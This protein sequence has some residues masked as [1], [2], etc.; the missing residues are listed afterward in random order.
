VN[1]AHGPVSRADYVTLRR[2]VV[3]TGVFLLGVILQGMARPGYDPWQQSMSALS[4]GSGGWV[5]NVFFVLLGLALLHTVPVWTRV[6]AGGAGY[7]AYPL[8]TLLTGLSLIAAAGWSQDPA[9]GYDPEH[10]GLA[11]PTATGL[12]HLAAAAV[13]AA[14]SV[15][16]L[17]V[18]ANRFAGLASWRHW[19]RPTRVAAVLTMAS[20]VTY[21]AWSV[22][23]RGFA[24]AFERLVVA[25]PGIWGC[26][27]IARL[28]RGTPFVVHRALAS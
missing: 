19:V 16:A 22:Q 3:M 9:P 12:L 6:L 27:L 15:A 17:F 13:G 8:L 21:A 4:L 7:R 18:M 20:V 25:I 23:P 10:L 11:L 1:D 5:Q 24:G 28:G 14:S 26:A 2:A